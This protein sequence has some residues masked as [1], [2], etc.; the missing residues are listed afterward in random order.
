M[1][2]WRV[3]PGHRPNRG[4]E[5]NVELLRITE[6]AEELI[7]WA[8]QLTRGKENKVRTIADARRLI[9][10]LIA[11]GHESVLEHGV[12]TFLVE[13]ISRACLAQLTRHRLASYT[14]LS[15]RY[16]EP[17]RGEWVIPPSL[18]EGDQKLRERAEA[19]LDQAWEVY[20]DLREAG[21]PKEDARFFL[22]MATKTKLVMTA[23]FREW[24]HIIRLRTAP[25]A[26]WEIR[27]LCQ[28]IVEKLRDHAPSV[29][30]DVG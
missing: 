26:Q 16:T 3:L 28:K 14:V 10:S 18:A 15:Q 11:M 12:A 27:D 17:L 21:I 2:A 13:G 8:A 30:E 1:W 7:A 19:L 6:R 29:F 22:P 25:E 24:R 9:K 23:N 20:R 4:C 5:V